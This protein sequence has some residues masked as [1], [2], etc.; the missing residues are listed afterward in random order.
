MRLMVLGAKGFVGSAVVRQAVGR[1]LTVGA[2]SRA[3]TPGDRLAAVADSV[4]LLSAELADASEIAGAVR[5]W[6][7]DAIV[8]AAFPA[9]H[10]SGGSAGRLDYFQRGVAPAL[11]LACA[12][13][14]ANYRGTLVHAGSAMAFGATGKTHR[15]DDRL[16]PSTPRGVVK[17]ACSLI[18]EQA[19]QAAGF[20]FCELF[21]Y[22]VYG[23]WEQRGR[24]IPRLLRAALEGGTVS[25]TP[26][27]H[28]RN[29]V[30]VDDVAGACLAAATRATPGA[31]RVIVGSDRAVATTHEVARQLELIV[32]RTVV[33]DYS[34]PGEDRYG[35]ENLS[36]DPAPGQDAIGWSPTIG[37]AE[38][39]ASTWRWANT[40][41][42]RLHALG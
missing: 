18:Y 38:G 25:L 30:H 36:L 21:I 32:G 23:H 15:A 6:R 11:A 42:G 41:E 40:R 31:S 2:A 9:G 27:A 13:E 3:S 34:F 16:A 7:P 29:W 8:Q 12:L 5:D 19:S 28:P 35:D 33:G 4:E 1:G 10:G 39:L 24:L 20:R 37:L 26:V 14:T 22:S 17:A